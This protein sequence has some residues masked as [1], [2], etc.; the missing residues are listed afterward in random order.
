MNYFDY[1]SMSAENN[2]SLVISMSVGRKLFTSKLFDEVLGAKFG[3]LVRFV[4]PF[5]SRSG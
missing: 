4:Y 3:V 2:F 5:K 1:M